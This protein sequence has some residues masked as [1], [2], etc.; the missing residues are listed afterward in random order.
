MCTTTSNLLRFTKRKLA[1]AN[2]KAAAEMT[3]S[4]AWSLA[5]VLRSFV[6]VAKNVKIKRYRN[7]NGHRVYKNS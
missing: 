6:P 5:N 7:T 3:V 1:S 2:R 4:I